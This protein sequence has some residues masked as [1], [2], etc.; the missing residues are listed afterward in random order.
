M[1]NNID[2]MLNTGNNTNFLN[3]EIQRIKNIGKNNSPMAKTIRKF[4][5]INSAW[6]N[7]SFADRGMMRQK[8]IDSDGD[9]TPDIFDCRPFDVM[10]QDR[11]TEE[12]WNRFNRN[13]DKQKQNN[14][15]NG[16]K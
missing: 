11:V 1:L 16:W 10:R 6:I 13:I 4:D 2:K 5:S 7:M 8:Y 14:Y 15:F 3:M 9:R 12:G